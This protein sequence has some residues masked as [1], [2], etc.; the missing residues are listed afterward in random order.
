MCE[1][2]WG[3]TQRCLEFR[4]PCPTPGPRPVDNLGLL[5]KAVTESLSRPGGMLQRFV[6]V[7]ACRGIDAPLDGRAACCGYLTFAEDET[8]SLVCQTA[9]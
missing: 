8:E 2:L 5:F 4:P 6:R 7:L 9:I 3:P 1:C